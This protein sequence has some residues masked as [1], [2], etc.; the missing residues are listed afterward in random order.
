MNRSR[1]LAAALALAG[2]LGAAEVRSASN[3]QQSRLKAFQD[4][5]Q[6]ERQAQ[7]LDKDRKALFARYPTPELTL[8]TA[9]G[10][11]APSGELPS[12]SVGSETNIT[13]TGR[14]VPGSL[15][16]VECQGTEVLAEK[17]TES[18]AELKVKVTAAAPA[19]QCDVRI[20]SPVSLAS[21]RRPAFRVIGN[22]QWELSL[23]NGMKARMKTAA[24]PDTSLIT[25]SSEWFDKGGKPLGTREVRLDRT[26][27]GYTVT[28]ER[29]E[30]ETAASDKAMAESGKAYKN[31]DNQ[32]AAAEIQAKMQG[33]CMKLPPDKMGACIQKYTAEM[34]ALSQK[35]QSQAQAGEQKAAAA[36]VGCQAMTLSVNEGKV[37]GKGTSCGAPGEV[38]V[39]G[40]VTATK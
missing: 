37:T 10:G 19:G 22:Y 21:A 26:F 27:E 6:K 32:K 28:V 9:A 1:F 24:K 16:S 34:T 33:E 39:T 31:Q 8:V 5:A 40:T 35:V 30:A 23:A 14:F 2:L 20:I 13:V 18:R 29:T 4:K 15:P 7:K 36:A 25:G 17:V 3:D 38:N 12:V 11:S